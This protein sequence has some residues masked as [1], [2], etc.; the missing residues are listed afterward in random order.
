VIGATAR[1]DQSGSERVFRDTRQAFITI[2]G[3]HVSISQKLASESK[4]TV[5]AARQFAAKVNQLSQQLAA[6]AAA[7][8]QAAQ[9][10]APAEQATD[11]PEQIRKLGELKEQGLLTD[12]EFA[13]KKTELLA[14]L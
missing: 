1:V 4:F 11:I 3:P 14:R 9:V 5:Q 12:E 7:A 2:E 13:A 6:K 10:Q 8:Q